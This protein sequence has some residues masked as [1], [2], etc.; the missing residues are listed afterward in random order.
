MVAEAVPVCIDRGHDF[1]EH[2]DQ[3]NMIFGRFKIKAHATVLAVAAS[4]VAC[5]GGNGARSPDIGAPEVPFRQKTRDEKRAFM[6]ARVLPKMREV[7]SGLDPKGTA[8]FG[9]ETCHGA[10]MEAVDFRM[11]NSLYALPEKDTI[12]EATS[13]DEKT[14]K[15]MVEHVVPAFAALLSEKAGTPGNPDASKGITCF[16]CHPHE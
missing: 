10:D 6:G 2:R 14:T 3:K 15:F 1:T 4:T 12:A 5:G 9:C 8:T 7:F 11:P 13:Y 16:T